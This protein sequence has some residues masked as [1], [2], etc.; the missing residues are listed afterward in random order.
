MGGM[1][2]T[3]YMAEVWALYK[4][5][6]SIKGLLGKILVVIDN[7][8][9]QKEAEARRLMGLSGLQNGAYVWSEIQ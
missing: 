8:S 4:L 3:S 6:I 9:V 5:M 2:Q 1:D 7:E